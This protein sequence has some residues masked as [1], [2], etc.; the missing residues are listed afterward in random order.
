VRKPDGLRGLAR[1]GS[2]EEA[3]GIQFGRATEFG[4][5]LG[6]SSLIAFCDIS[7]ASAVEKWNPR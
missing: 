3:R 4:Q 2:L 5:K 6:R 1:S 7:D